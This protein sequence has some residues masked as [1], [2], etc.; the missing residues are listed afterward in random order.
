MRKF[1]YNYMASALMYMEA[2]TYL[3]WVTLFLFFYIEVFLLVVAVGHTKSC[4][5]S[6]FK[7]L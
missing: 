7:K 5:A 4:A 2:L 1:Y 3:Q 6:G